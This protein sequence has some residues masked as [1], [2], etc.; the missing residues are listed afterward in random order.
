MG[1]FLKSAG[2]TAAG[3]AAGALAFE[4][5]R[6]MFGGAEHLMGFGNQPQMGGRGFLGGGDPVEGSVVNN[7]YDHPDERSA[8]ADNL[9]PDDSVQYDDTDVP[10]D[11]SSSDSSTDDS[12]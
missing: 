5:I 7:Y 1:S 4:G 11:D 3:V 6:S 9:G 8:A 10:G 12:V 2:T